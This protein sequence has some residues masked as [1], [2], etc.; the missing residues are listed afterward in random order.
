MLSLAKDFENHHLYPDFVQVQS[1]LNKHQ[2]VCWLAGGAVR[3]LFLGREV[4]DFDLVTDASTE[5][6]KLIFPEA[7][8]V[9][10]KFGVLKLVLNDGSFF[11]LTTFRQEADYVD[12]RR[13]SSVSASTPIQ[14]AL[15]RDFTVNA[16]FWDQ[17]NKKL[18]DYVGGV[19]DLQSRALKCVGNA[20]VRF[21]EDY[22]RLIRLVRF[23]AQLSLAIDPLTE[24]AAE[25]QMASITLVSGERIWSELKKINASKVWASVLKLSLFHKM[26]NSIFVAELPLSVKTLE[27]HLD[28]FYLLSCLQAEPEFIKQI[29]TLK[30][31]LSKDELSL[32]N[33]FVE[34][35]KDFQ[36][37]ELENLTYE[38]GKRTQLV[39]VL[40][41]FVE[42]DLFDPEKLQKAQQ[43]LQKHSDTLVSGLDLQNLLPPAEIGTALKKIRIQQFKG[44]LTS[45]QQ[46][47]NWIKKK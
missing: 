47:L 37:M 42:L 8:L 25:A 32:Y 39:E 40:Q 3:D 29:L 41:Y 44:N 9:G 22:L 20:S 17:Q 2:F 38:I 21:A 28:L 23:S 33:L 19:N 24:R 10:E 18:I 11:D 36:Q 35:K 15:R 5:N 26:M 30:L 27:N 45:K 7:L 4:S 13:P 46:A 31:H 1:R 43:L 12:G 14:D 34:V 6:L 16:L